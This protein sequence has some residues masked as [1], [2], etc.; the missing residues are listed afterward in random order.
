MQDDSHFLK[1][2]P[3]ESDI[4]SH[5]R[6]APGQNPKVSILCLTY[7]QRQYIEDAITGFLTQ[8]TTYP[9]EVIINDDCSTDGTQDLL[10]LLAK[11]YP[12]IVRLNLQL[13][14]QHS[15]GKKNLPSLIELAKGDYYAFCEGDDYWTSSQKLQT[16]IDL[17]E[18]RPSAPLSF[19]ACQ[20]LVNGVYKKSYTPPEKKAA[21]TADSFLIYG[22]N[23]SP[24]A[25]CVYR[26]DFFQ[27]L[28]EWIYNVSVLDILLES[29]AAE[30]ACLAGE[31][32]ALYIDE[33]MSAY[34]VQSEGSWSTGP[35]Q[36]IKTEYPKYRSALALL[37]QYFDYKYNDLI[38]AALKRR[39][40]VDAHRC[41]IRMD[42]AATREFAR[43]SISFSKL[44]LR[45]LII[46]FLSFS[47][48]AYRQIRKI[49]G[50]PV[51]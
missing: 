35:V 3:S 28:P 20:F 50:K 6:K 26:A 49:M 14:N 22:G 13:E 9:F 12:K 39:P 16:Q 24:T 2:L 15:Q 47:P 23:L 45:A 7:N 5:W 18:S 46:Y 29:I 48:I 42:G 36:N 19:H 51:I 34:R 1:S 37:N 43:S 30:K 25:S 41:L 4:I 21:Y 11:A 31:S 17:M 32:G 8:V 40:V 38:Q 10:R 33:E 44:G 27:T